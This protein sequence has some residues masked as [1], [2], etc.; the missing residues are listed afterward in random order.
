[1]SGGNETFFIIREV[2]MYSFI[3]SSRG[4]ETVQKS[5]EQYLFSNPILTLGRIQWYIHR[6]DQDFDLLIYEP[7]TGKYGL[8]ELKRKLTEFGN[9][10]EEDEIHWWIFRRESQLD[11]LLERTT[12]ALEFAIRLKRA[13]EQLRDRHDE[14]DGYDEFLVK[15]RT[16]VEDNG[17]TL[18]GLEEYVQWLHCHNRLAPVMLFT[19][20]VWGSTRLSERSCELSADSIENEDPAILRRLSEIVLGLFVNGLFSF[21]RAFQDGSEE[22]CQDPETSAPFRVAEKPIVR[23][24]AARTL[25][26]FAEHFNFIRQSLENIILDVNKCKRQQNILRSDSFWR[27]FISEAVV[28]RIAG[29]RIKRTKLIQTDKYV[30]AVE[31]EMVV[32]ID[33][34]TEPCYESE[35]VPVFS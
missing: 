5:H 1:M 20:R 17:P 29:E 15:L 11:E 24:A 34:P 6:A 19:Y 10:F 14:Y 27:S 4:F 23:R 26:Q 28:M 13:T 31:V 2:G 9:D 3:M 18:A 25:T 30:V 21:D 16:F 32:P 12:I 33:D 35:T 7:T 8:Q 22:Y